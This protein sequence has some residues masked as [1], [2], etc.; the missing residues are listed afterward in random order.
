MW[1]LAKMVAVRSSSSAAAI[2][3]SGAVAGGERVFRGSPR[4][5]RVGG[6][7][8]AAWLEA[9]SYPTRGHA[10]CVPALRRHRLSAQEIKEDRMKS[11]DHAFRDAVATS[12]A[13]SVLSSAALAAASKLEAGHAA[14]AVNG[15]SHWL[16]GDAQAR[17]DEVS[18]RHTG[19]GY[20]THH[21]SAYFWT[22]LHERLVG[23]WAEWSIPNALVAGLGTAAVACAIDYTVT[24]RRF[25]PGFELRLSRPAMT[26]GFVAFGLGIA[27]TAIQRR[28]RRQRDPSASLYPAG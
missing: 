6:Q 11:W 22:V 4:R 2:G 26:V 18:L 17:T 21:A 10:G 28:Q 25:T 19:V 13:A 16:W 15:T 23:D 8:Q 7:W 9:E 5:P 27:S 3:G 1:L 20:A 14:A 12:T 24:P